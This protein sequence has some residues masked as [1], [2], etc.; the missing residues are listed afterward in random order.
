[1]GGMKSA[2]HLD[3]DNLHAL[4]DAA[5]T[6]AE[7]FLAQL[8][9]VPVVPPSAV[10]PSHPLPVHGAGAVAALQAFEAAYANAFTASAGPRY[11]GFVTGGSTPAAIMGDWLTSALD[12]NAHDSNGAAN[13]IEREVLQML[14][15]L[16][17]LPHAFTGAFVSGATMSN[18][19]G[20]AQARQWAAKQHGRDAAVD[21]LFGL[22][23]LRVFS[24]AAHST[25]FK[26]LSMAGVGRGAVTRLPLLSGR[27]AVDIDALRAA[28]ASQNGAPCVVVANAGT[29][30]SVDFDDIAAI[31][32]LKQQHNFW[33]HVDGA[34]G[35][36]A[37]C[38][39]R[40]AHLTRGWEHAD[41]ITVDFHKWLN[42]PYDSAIQLSR[43]PDLLVDV[44]QNSGAAYL[45]APSAAVFGH[46]GPETSRRFR[47][48][49]AW[50]T[51][52]AYG[53]DGH[54]E[55]VEQ[56]CD[57]AAALG[58]RV[59]A[60]SKFVLVAPVR[61]NV[62]CFTLPGASATDIAAFLS[63]VHATGAAFFTASVLHGTPCIRAAFS[64]WRTT[65]N[66]VDI[67]WR[68]L[69]DV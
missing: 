44:F 50:F 9:G 63:R 34:F 36:F 7:A 23:P 2:L 14:R 31:A 25:I 26:A 56:S 8:G 69:C 45:G 4:L 39:P 27:E 6:R 1:M 41:S 35:G 68:A 60:S 57:M 42:V 11:F 15:D 33:L 17:G 22:P 67:A 59:T 53:A 48:L 18:F 65:A 47:A 66:D 43:H 38:S 3:S 21:G 55:I 13:H 61:M 46:I 40:F 10:L 24:G 28:L 62:V 49:S 12:Q 52:M 5:Q 64:N 20:L 32:A 51:L 37:A 29:V 58:A 16:F 19:V 54:R 30:N